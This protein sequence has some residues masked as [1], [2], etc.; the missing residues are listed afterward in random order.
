MRHSGRSRGGDEPVKTDR[1]IEPTEHLYALD[2]LARPDVP[3]FVLHGSLDLAVPHRTARDTA[4]RTDGVL[5]TIERAGHSWLLRDPETLPAIFAE[6]LATELGAGI[7]RSLRAAGV[8]KKYPT[9]SDVEAVCYSD[10]ARVFAL[11][12]AVSRN[13][14]VGRHPRPNHL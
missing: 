5:V 9:L 1:G 3:V 13:V 14:I 11:A 6:L 8:R 4:R 2:E 10:D 7:R 12:P